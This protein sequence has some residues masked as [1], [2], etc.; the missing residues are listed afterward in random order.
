MW[1]SKDSGALALMGLGFTVLATVAVA[2]VFLV[3]DQRRLRNAVQSA[4]SRRLG[5]MSLDRFSQRGRRLLTH[6][7][8]PACW[9]GAFPL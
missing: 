1:K 5:R 9:A 7:R 4:L 3:N 6:C 2:I 8:S